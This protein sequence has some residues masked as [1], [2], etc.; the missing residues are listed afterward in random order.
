MGIV[1]QQVT[2]DDRV[3]EAARVGDML[4]QMIGLPVTVSESDSE[5]RGKLFELHARL[6]FS[7]FPNDSIK[8]TA[9]WPGAV[10][11]HLQLAGIA[12]FPF[13]NAVQGMN[14]APGTQAVY[15]T[16]YLGHEPTL[17]FATVL[18]LVAL[19][20][21]PC[22]SVPEAIRREYAVRISVTELDR[23]HRTF[24][25]QQRLAWLLGVISFPILVPM[26][27]LSLGWGLATL[28]WRIGKAC[29]WYKSHGTDQ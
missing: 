16:G 11:E 10:K 18:A 2:F 21:R 29:R 6:A 9:Y 8:L 5:V 23:R 19:G 17:L 1:V 25:R 7:R 15:V 3:P 12:A 20:G 4:T 13:A 27:F 24:R 14:E 26:W 22:T 28:P